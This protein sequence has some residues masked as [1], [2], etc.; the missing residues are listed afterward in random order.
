MNFNFI[1][2]EIKEPK[3]IFHVVYSLNFD[4]YY[5]L[6]VGNVAYLALLPMQGTPESNC[7]EVESCRGNDRVGAA[8]A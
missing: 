5:Y 6:C 8:V 3:R 7:F 4:C 1:A 2:G